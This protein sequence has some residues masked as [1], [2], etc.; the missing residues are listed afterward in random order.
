M[1][2]KEQESYKVL[3]KDIQPLSYKDVAE[4]WEKNS[5]E[6]YHALVAI[7]DLPIV[8][9][10]PDLKIYAWCR[11]K[12]VADDGSEAHFHWHGL[13]HFPERKLASWKMHKAMP[14]KMHF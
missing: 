1:E 8:L 5:K 13:V 4:D 2:D 11:C 9:A 6:W 14:M 7:V 10:I 3:I 12:V